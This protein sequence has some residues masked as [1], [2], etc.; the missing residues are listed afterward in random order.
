M[1]QK[2]LIT[3]QE[4][5]RIR[6][7]YGGLLFE[8]SSNDITFIV[9]DVETEDTLPGANVV[10]YNSDGK[11]INGVRTDIHGSATISVPDN[12][13]KYGVSFVGYK[14]YEDSLEKSKTNALV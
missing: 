7:L 12:A 5:I 6:K 10:I 13:I 8:Q 3:E 9:K 14:N 1:S 11:A 4:K 2:F